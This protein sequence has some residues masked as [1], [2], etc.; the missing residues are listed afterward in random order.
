MGETGEKTIEKNMKNHCNNNNNGL[1]LC[2][3][4]RPPRDRKRPSV[5]APENYSIF[6]FFFG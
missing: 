2:R 6:F 4:H 5:D 3:P 1:L